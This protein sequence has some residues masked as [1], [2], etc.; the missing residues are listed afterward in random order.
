MKILTYKNPLFYLIPLLVL[1]A[2]SC[3]DED[4]G[5]S[6]IYSNGI[7]IS[8]QGSYQKNNGSVSFYSYDADTVINNIFELKNGSP[9]GDIVQ[10]VTISGE[11]CYIVVNNSNK[12]EVV[13]RHTFE[14]LGTIVVNQPRYMV[15]NNEKAYVSSWDDN[16]IKVVNLSDYTICN[17]IFVGEGPEELVLYNTS[18]F[19]TNG[20]I[21]GYDSTVSVIDIESE[22]VTNSIVVGYNPK[23]LVLDNSGNLWVLCMGREIYDATWTYIEDHTPSALYRITLN[24]FSSITQY[25]LFEDQHPSQLD[26]NSNNKILYVGAGYGFN[27]LYAVDIEASTIIKIIDKSLTGFNYDESTGNLMVLITPNYTQG[28]ELR[29][30]NS[31]GTLINTYTVGIGP[32]STSLN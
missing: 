16:S 7:F 12:I 1:F 10:S 17:S 11:Q 4:T 20:G 27:G 29:S 3:N 15:V 19:V 28:G 13:D 21:Y 31:N 25:S 5:P 6:G 23:D 8:N 22:S 14:S 32:G 9:L 24:D 18:L 30:Y 2:I 26:I